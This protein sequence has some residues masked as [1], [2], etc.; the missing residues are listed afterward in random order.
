MIMI[1]FGIHDTLLPLHIT[2]YYLLIHIVISLPD[3]LRPAVT[4]L[5]N[6][7]TSM[8]FTDNDEEKRHRATVLITN[9]NG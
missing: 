1:I 9:I 3:I 8:R 5:T 4:T 2:V 7:A 6:W